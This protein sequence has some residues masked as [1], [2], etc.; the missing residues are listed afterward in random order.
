MAE[1]FRCWHQTAVDQRW[2]LVG[3]TVGIEPGMVAAIVWALMDFASRQKQRGT[4]DGFDADAYA[5]FAGVQTPKV[6]AV[7]AAL[8]AKG[9][10]RDGRFVPEFW[11]Q[12]IREDNSADR[13]RA[14]RERQ[15][16]QHA[17]WEGQTQAN[18]QQ[19]TGDIA[20]PG[21]PSHAPAWLLLSADFNRDDR[22]AAIA[23][24]VGV[25]LSVVEA[26]VMDLIDHA[27]SH[28]HTGTVSDF[29]ID[30]EAEF[31]ACDPGKV[32]AI[33]KELEGFG[34]IHGGQFA[35]GDIWEVDVDQPA[36]R[37]TSAAS[38]Q[39]ADAQDL[40]GLNERERRI[41]EAR[42]LDA[43]TTQEALGIEFDISRE[44]VRQIETRAVEKVKKA[45]A[46][47]LAGL[48]PYPPERGAL[49]PLSTA[50]TVAVDAA[51][52]VAAV[53]T[54]PRFPTAAPIRSTG[55][56][57]T[58]PAWFEP[59]ISDEDLLE[60]LI[61]AADGNVRRVSPGGAAVPRIMDVSAIRAAIAA[62]ADLEADVLP[63]IRD[64]VAVP[65]QPP[66]TLWPDWVVD[67][68]KARQIRRSGRT[69]VAPATVPRPQS[70][71]QPAAVDPL[72]VARPRSSAPPTASAAGHG[73]FDMSEVVA[74][75]VAGTLAWD[76]KRFGPA[77]G[78]PG[79]R[80]SREALTEG[81]FFDVRAGDSR[82]VRLPT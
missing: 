22:W 5:A 47:R 71:D 10:I 56:Q 6:V 35:P 13:A 23:A 63:A 82:S 66:I 55:G 16:T 77:P 4:V 17:D 79:C 73:D 15:R 24:A 33:I 32:V 42:R 14:W 70:P 39:G 28:Q 31:L 11:R 30:A 3:R 45:I 64:L 7:I 59:N 68:I 81:G 21:L 26:V 41:F 58:T 19:S 75:F 80:V 74:G 57:G 2:V 9:I 62:G 43:P 40:A 46:K 53:G 20:A 69:A 18:A 52:K 72:P 51:D 8:T 49:D 36:V 37:E 67:E 48:A 27:A 12:P 54:D 29:D 76:A 65:D 44:R 38:V 34:I 61:E 60:L 50:S 25:R 1:F 78:Q